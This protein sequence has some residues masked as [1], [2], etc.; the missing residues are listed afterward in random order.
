MI[1][2]SIIVPVFNAG[3][4]IEDTIQSVRSQTYK[5]WELIL[6]D[7]YSSDNSADYIEKLAAEDERIRLIRNDRN[8][9]AAMARNTGIEAAQGRYIAFLDADDIWAPDKLE[10]ELAYMIETGA[11]FIFTSYHF[12]DENA[13]PTGKAVHV[14]ATLTY[15]QALSRTVIFTSTVLIDTE[16]IGK[17]L[18]RMPQIASEDTAT[19]GI[20]LKSGVVAHGLDKLLVIYRR[21]AKSLSS[22]KVNAVK[23]IW[24]LYRNVVGLNI[25]EAAWYFAGWAVRASRR[26]IVKDRKLS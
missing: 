23:R 12:G 17:E 21:P 25:I 16:K 9:G 6:V 15:R 13:V 18:I 1:M 5:D 19:W 8:E 26:R 4:Y 7:D 11:G 20:I 22:N 14:P 2:I 3:K 10:E 24:G